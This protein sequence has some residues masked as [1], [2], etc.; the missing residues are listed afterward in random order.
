M[1]RLKHCG[2]GQSLIL[3][4]EHVVGR[5]ASA[6]QRL[7]FPLVS[8]QHALLR[9]HASTWEVRDLGSRNGTSVNG[10][11]LVPAQS[12]RLEKGDVLRFGDASQDWMLE[13][14]SAPATM[15]VP[16]DGGDPVTADSGVFG[17]PSTECPD[18]M[19]YS[20]SLGQWQ[21]ERQDEP[22]TVLADGQTFE[23]GGRRWR[24]FCPD[25][26]PRTATVEEG[27]EV[28]FL[29]LCLAV[30]RDEEHVELKVEC[31]GQT[32]DLGSRSH[33][34]LLLTLARERR[35]DADAGVPDSACGWMY[36]DTLLDALAIPPTQL[37]ID[38]FRIRKHFAT[39]QLVD[40]AHII[41]R[42]PGTKQLR[43]GT[44]RIAIATI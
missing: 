5:S 17:F 27:H 42:R 19:I 41:E 6:S 33:N 18:V 13:D 30:S 7:E 21:L 34:Y 3:R 40:P 32:H 22:I 4:P 11:R 10:A 28:R 39:I 2:S 43:L 37:N 9:W 15:I 16:S 24:F 36:Q 12:V 14:A 26:A 38:V 35:R 1:G 31:C 20:G 44:S 29:R 8:S 23:A 25:S